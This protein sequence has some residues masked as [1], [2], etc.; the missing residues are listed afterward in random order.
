MQSAIKIE[1][2]IPTP[3]MR[4]AK[5]KY[6]WS[7]MLV[8]DSFFV[9]GATTTKIATAASTFA[10]YHK[11]GYKFTVRKEGNGARVWRVA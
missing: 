3:A 9:P 10:R 7:Q 8:G 2:G 1:A 11:N 4:N 6:P 5:A